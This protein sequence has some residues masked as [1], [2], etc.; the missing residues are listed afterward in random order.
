MSTMSMSERQLDL[1]ASWTLQTQ[2]LYRVQRSEER[3]IRKP[4][5]GPH[6]KWLHMYHRTVRCFAASTKTMVGS[7]KGS[8]D[9]FLQSE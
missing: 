3:H 9:P 1:F 7:V 2:R 8:W 5:I 6:Y 4:D